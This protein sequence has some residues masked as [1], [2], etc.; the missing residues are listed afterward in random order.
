MQIVKFFL[1]TLGKAS[2]IFMISLTLVAIGFVMAALADII[3][4]VGRFV[5]VIG[6]MLVDIAKLLERVSMA[7]IKKFDSL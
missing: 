5:S 1:I 6:N 4:F 7:A 2:M 3:E